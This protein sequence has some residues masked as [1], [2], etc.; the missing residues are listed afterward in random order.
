MNSTVSAFNCSTGF[1]ATIWRYSEFRSCC[2]LHA[3][4]RAGSWL[5]EGAVTLTH[6]R[7]FQAAAVT[8]CH[9]LIASPRNWRSVLREMR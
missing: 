7:F 6:E 2:C 8:A 3:S 1:R 9:V 5:P 4:E